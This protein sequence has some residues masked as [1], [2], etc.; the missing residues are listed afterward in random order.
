MKLT[1]GFGRG[2]RG[3]RSSDRILQISKDTTNE[4]ES[5]E[6]SIENNVDNVRSAEK[7][8]VVERFQEILKRGEC[9]LKTFL[10]EKRNKLFHLT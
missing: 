2:A 10:K 7:T 6:V 3:G 4:I 5:V 8:P 9:S 1:D